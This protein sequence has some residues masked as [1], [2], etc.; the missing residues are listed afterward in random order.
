MASVRTTG[1]RPTLHAV[2]AWAMLLLLACIL[3]TGLI[4]TTKSYTQA[5]RLLGQYQADCAGVPTTPV[6]SPTGACYYSSIYA[7]YDP[8]PPDS[9]DTTTY[10]ELVR[11]GIANPKAGL[12]GDFNGGN[13]PLAGNAD[14][15]IWRNQAVKIQAGQQWVLTLDNP[16]VQANITELVGL[17]AGSVVAWL[18]VFF[19]GALLLRGIK[20]GREREAQKEKEAGRHVGS[21]A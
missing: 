9:T 18:G 8:P 7:S 12:V 4:S 6:K 5:R 11:P 13:L 10:A 15:Q 14:V 20:A 17:L 21:P 19:F 3:L 16:I 2:I 1:I